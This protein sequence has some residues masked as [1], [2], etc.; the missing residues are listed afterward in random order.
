MMKLGF[1]HSTVAALT[2]VLLAMAPMA[3]GEDAERE[4]TLSA[5]AQTSVAQDW[6]SMRFAVRLDGA[7][8]SALQSELKQRLQQAIDAVQGM[9]Q[10]DDLQ[11]Q[12]GGFRLTPRYNSAGASMGWRGSAELVLRGRDFGRIG[13]ASAKLHDLAVVSVDMSVSNALAR[14]TRESVRLE[15]IAAFRE[16]AASVA[17]AFG[18]SDYDL[19]DVNVGSDSPDMG[20]GPMM[21]RAMAADAAPMPVVAGQEDISV[22][23]T[24][25]IRLR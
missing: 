16:Q 19:L 5:S 2:C 24:G 8:A 20:R 1:K 6:L 25:R 14:Q 23:V 9:A 22:Q 21:M 3:H 13:Q 12:T 10:A 17:K 11:V 7:D 18:Y 15:A 4:V